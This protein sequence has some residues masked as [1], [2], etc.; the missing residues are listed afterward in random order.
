MAKLRLAEPVGIPRIRE[1]LESNDWAGDEEVDLSDL[2]PSEHGDDD[3]PFGTF[4]FEE[5]EMGTELLG[6]KNAVNNLE[7]TEASLPETDEGAR[8]VEEL[9]FM[10][11]KMQSIKGMPKIKPARAATK[12]TR[13]DM[14]ADMDPTAR[15]KFAA[16]AVNDLLKTR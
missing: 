16:R 8:Q 12:S 5:A 4:A 11:R 3:E 7:D 1:A 6:L 10:M 15:R 2:D 9:E 14:G 13:P